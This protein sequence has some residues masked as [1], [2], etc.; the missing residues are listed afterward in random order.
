MPIAATVAVL[1]RHAFRK[2]EKSD[3]FGHEDDALVPVTD[4]MAAVMPGHDVAGTKRQT[5]GE[6]D[7]T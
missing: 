7:E 6:P 4:A 5:P 2:Y 3:F 1:I